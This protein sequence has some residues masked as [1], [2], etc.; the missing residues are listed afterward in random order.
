M[1]TLFKQLFVEVSGFQATINTKLQEL[2]ESLERNTSSLTKNN[3]T[4][5]QL[6]N[7]ISTKDQ[8]IQRNFEQ[9]NQEI[10]TM[11]LK[12]Q[13]S[14]TKID[15]LQVNI[16]AIKRAYDNEQT[17]IK[18]RIDDLENDKDEFLDAEEYTKEQIQELIKLTQEQLDSIDRAISKIKSDNST[19]PNTKSANESLINSKEQVRMLLTTEL[20]E[21]SEKLRH[22]G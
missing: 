5:Q 13:V 16:V 15:K 12:N 9:I 19:D 10:R 11:T 3:Q 7:L 4:I 22:L 18:K 20:S 6:T 14:S 8:T 2:E 17:S 1:G 21:L